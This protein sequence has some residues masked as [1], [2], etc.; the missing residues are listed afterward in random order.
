MTAKDSTAGVDFAGLKQ[1]ALDNYWMPFTQYNDM[2]EP[3]GLMFIVDGDGIRLTDSEGKSYIDGI[4]GLFLVNAGHGRKEIADAVAEQLNHVHYASTFSYAN[5]PAV[6]LAQRIAGL[7]PGDLNKV[8]FAS[9]GSEAVDT[10]LKIARQYHV[11]NGEP[12]RTKLIARKHS[13]HGVSMGALSVNSSAFVQRGIWE[14]MLA[15]VRFVGNSAE[16][17][18][19]LVEFEGPDSFA[20]FITEPISISKGVEVPPDDYWPK[21]REICDK[22]GILLIADEV[23][24]GFGRTGKM[25]A[26]EHWGVIPDMMTFAKGVTSGYMPVG[27]VIA[28]PKVYDAFKGDATQTF[29]HGYTYSGHPAGAAA[30]LANLDILERENLVDNAAEVGDYLI[31]QLGTLKEHSMVK[32]IHGIGLLTAVHLTKDKATGEPLDKTDPR[33]KSLDEKLMS[34]GLLTR[35]FPNI[36]LAPPLNITKEEVDEMVGIIDEALTE[37]EAGK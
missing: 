37:V 34:K 8:F 31:G 20:A 35:S 5:I 26:M 3:D 28:S 1:A 17:V 2:A 10:A 15:Q 4:G 23:I 25:F 13:Y 22:H 14:P 12:Q 16:E 29:T 27:G 9:G 11:N 6:Q 30:A 7:A 21:L 19:E 33:V 18:E 32:E 36:S 24:N